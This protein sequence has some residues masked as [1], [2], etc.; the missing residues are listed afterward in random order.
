MAGSA[1]AALYLSL[2]L[3]EATYG[4]VGAVHLVGLCVYG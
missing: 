3:I 4:F 1:V 2:P